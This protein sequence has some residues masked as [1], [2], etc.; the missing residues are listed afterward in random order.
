MNRKL[1]LGYN[2]PNT[3]VNFPENSLIAYAE[4]ISGKI[5]I[6]KSWT[7]TDEVTNA[8]NLISCIQ[9]SRDLT[10]LPATTNLHMFFNTTSVDLATSTYTDISTNYPLYI[11]GTNRTITTTTITIT[12]RSTVERLFK[13]VSNMPIEFSNLFI[14]YAPTGSQSDTGVIELDRGGPV[15][16][17]DMTLQGMFDAGIISHLDS[18]PGK[19]DASTITNV[20]IFAWLGYGYYGSFIIDRETKFG[21]IENL[22]VS[23]R[24][25]AIT[26][27]ELDY[28]FN[29][30][31]IIDDGGKV[32]VGGLNATYD[33]TWNGSDSNS[34]LIINANNSF[35]T[36]KDMQD[37]TPQITVINRGNCNTLNGIMGPCVLY[38]SVTVNVVEETTSA[39]IPKV[40]VICMDDA[41]GSIIESGNTN[42]LGSI[43]FTKLVLGRT[44]MLKISSYTQSFTV[45]GIENET[46]IAKIN[47]GIKYTLTYYSNGGTEYLASKHTIGTSIKTL[48]VPSKTGYTFVG[49]FDESLTQK[50]VAPLIM[51]KNYNLYAAWDI[52]EEPDNPDIPDPGPDEPDDPED[53]EI[54]SMN[55][56]GYLE[57]NFKSTQTIE[58]LTV[59]IANIDTIPNELVGKMVFESGVPLKIRLPVG[60]YRLSTS[61][62]DSF[63]NFSVILTVVNNSAVPSTLLCTI[64]EGD[65]IGIMNPNVPGIINKISITIPETITVSL[66]VT[67]VYAPLKNYQVN[68]VRLHKW[69]SDDGYLSSTFRTGTIT[70]IA[71]PTSDTQQVT[72]IFSQTDLAAIR[73]LESG[74]T[75]KAV[76]Y[77]QDLGDNSYSEII[78]WDNNSHSGGVN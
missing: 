35:F 2:T 77:F 48:P 49:W 33:L 17:K 39:P 75:Y 6:L 70:G 40:S 63:R 9:F 78:R 73:V 43:T 44:Y 4:S 13:T 61:D 30:S 74:T 65:G 22:E 69:V 55:D 8:K 5:T 37:K 11:H 60:N 66:P 76:I 31:A 72:A 21:K 64:L 42:A 25:R 34:Q 23:N 18:Q 15:H 71:F 47:S 50:Y 10:N 54:V 1:L 20:N 19:A 59:T 53:I 56:E 3:P 46:W 36:Y 68:V 32:E 52:S 41:S 12:E 51:N 7:F 38:K 57:V 24:N 14:H 16:F 28:P 45:A 58:Y 27:N 26:I 67:F 62:N 29:V